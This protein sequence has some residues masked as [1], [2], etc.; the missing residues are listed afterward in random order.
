ML[1]SATWSRSSQGQ[2]AD[3]AARKSL[4]GPRADSAD[5]DHAD[6]RSGQ[7]VGRARTVQA[8]DAAEATRAVGASVHR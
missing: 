7:T 4:G 6:V 2:A 5:A 3:T 8:I 1:D